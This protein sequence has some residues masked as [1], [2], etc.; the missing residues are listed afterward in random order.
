LGYYQRKKDAVGGK[1]AVVASSRKMLEALYFMMTRK[2][3]FH[4]H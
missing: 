1:K 3:V 4:A 2:E